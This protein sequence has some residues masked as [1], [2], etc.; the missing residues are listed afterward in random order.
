MSLRPGMS[1]RTLLLESQEPTL[2][3]K[4]AEEKLWL[5]LEGNI[6]E[7]TGGDLKKLYRNR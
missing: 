7:T 3:W 1:C 2:F 4:K 6:E 5:D